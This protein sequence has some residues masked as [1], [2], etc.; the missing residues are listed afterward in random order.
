MPSDHYSS[1]SPISV[2]STF[3]HFC[4]KTFS[5]ARL[6]FLSTNCSLLLDSK[7]LRWSLAANQPS[8]QKSGPNRFNRSC[9]WLGAMK[10]RTLWSRG[11]FSLFFAIAQTETAHEKSPACRVQISLPFNMVQLVESLPFHI[12]ES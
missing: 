2:A 9:D 12:P 5:F 7:F 1:P 8:C 10:A 3:R 4:S 11:F 6:L